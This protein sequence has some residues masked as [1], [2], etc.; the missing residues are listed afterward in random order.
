M[1]ILFLNVNEKSTKKGYESPG[2]ITPAYPVAS[3]H[4]ISS[5]RLI[6]HTPS[7][8]HSPNSTQM[9]LSQESKTHNINI[10]ASRAASRAPRRAAAGPNARAAPLVNGDDELE[11]V[12]ENGPNEDRRVPD[13]L[14]PEGL[15]LNTVV[16]GKGG[17]AVE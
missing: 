16:V 2:W 15:G 17:I 7:P 13:G 10:A 14:M 12:G 5:M 11:P 4:V 6:S 9:P 3:Q 8:F 1:D